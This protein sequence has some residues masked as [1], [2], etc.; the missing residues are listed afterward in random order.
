MPRNSFIGSPNIYGRIALILPSC[1]TLSLLCSTVFSQT[2]TA[3]ILLLNFRS[4]LLAPLVTRSNSLR[5]V[6]WKLFFLF[7][8]L[9]LQ[10]SPPMYWLDACFQFPSLIYLPAVH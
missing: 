1:S 5:E 3:S 10:V 7:Y 4:N 6:E 9:F 8:V 2:M